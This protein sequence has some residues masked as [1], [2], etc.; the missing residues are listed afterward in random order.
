MECHHHI[1]Y[2]FHSRWL[3]HTLIAVMHK[4]DNASPPTIKE[5]KFS[6]QMLLIS[7]MSRDHKLADTSSGNNSHSLN[8]PPHCLA[9]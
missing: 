5:P 9:G 1:S 7:S 6:V 4:S 8:G 2:N 3:L